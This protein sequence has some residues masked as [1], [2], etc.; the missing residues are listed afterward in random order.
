MELEIVI[1]KNAVLGEGPWWDE[2]IQKLYWIDGLSEFGDGNMLHRFDPSDSSDE[3]FPIGQHIGCAI[4]TRDGKVIMALQDGIYLYDLERRKLLEVSNLERDIENNRLNDGKVDSHGRLWFG[5]MSMT[6]NQPDRAFEVTGHFY[7]M[8]HNRTIHHMFGNVGISNG[9]AWSK[10]ETCMY[11]ID[12]TSQT[13]VAFDFDAQ[14]GAISGR[15]VIFHVDESEGVPDGMTIDVEGKLWIAHFGG[16]KISRVDP[17]TGKRLSEILLPCEQV[18]S[19]C[20]G[21]KIFD[22]L[23]ITTASIGLSKEQREKQPLAGCLFRAKPGVSGTKLH[24]F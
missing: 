12:S 3:E 7:K 5:S 10:D 24:K 19:C 8:E 11:Y 15:R 1:K 2:D 9:I 23:Y 22:D 14:S 13:V 18:T 4:P 17:D 6:A 16:W 21:G 20:F